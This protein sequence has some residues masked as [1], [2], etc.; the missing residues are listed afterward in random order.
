MNL[1]YSLACPCANGKCYQGCEG[2][3]NKVCSCK[4]RLYCSLLSF[5]IPFKH[6]DTN[7]D[8]KQCMS[9]IG[10]VFSACMLSCDNMD[11]PNEVS[12]CER[13]CTKEWKFSQIRCPCQVSRLLSHMIYHII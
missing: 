8:Y 13:V 12:S 1:L 4:V 7:E 6:L 5:K 9:D 11:N 3:E 2:C 10:D